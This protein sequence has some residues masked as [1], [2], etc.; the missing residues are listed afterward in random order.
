MTR[1]SLSKK[2]RFEVF[3]R[4]SF[5]C[6][7]C[8]AKAPD[9][10][11]EADHIIPVAKD[12]TSDLLNLITS[13]KACNS[14]KSDRELSDNSVIEKQR[15]QLA[16]LQERKEQIEMMLAWQRELSKLDD[17]TVDQLASFWSELVS[18][19]SLNDNGRRTLE[20]LK[21]KFALDEIM[22]AMRVAVS[23][24]IKYNEQNTPTHDSVEKAWA[25]IGGICNLKKAQVDKPYLKDLYYIRG[26]LRNRLNYVNDGMALSLLRKS[27]EL[28]AS[29][30][31]LKEHALQV[32]NWSQ[33]RSGVEA[34]IEQATAEETE[35]EEVSEPEEEETAKEPND[36]GETT[37]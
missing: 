1:E 13:C 30:E 19:Y 32:R 16:D 3:K 20:K 5:T 29:I 11:L 34:F 33:W 26:I 37:Q 17:F 25:K 4:D 18:P 9:V 31:S 22:E 10:V 12:G 35:A 23:Q 28:G 2:I 6:Q 7:Y 24:Y 36:D 15:K 14:G 21:R 27:V 8:G